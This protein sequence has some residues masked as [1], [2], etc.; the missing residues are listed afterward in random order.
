MEQKGNHLIHD[1]CQN[2]THSVH[3]IRFMN[4]GDKYFLAKTPEKCL[5]EAAIENKMIYLEACLQQYRHFSPFATFSDG[6]L[7][8]EA[9]TTLKRIAIRLATK[10][11]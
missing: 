3:G 1:L 10:W 5:Q 8:V 7:D 2:G 11:I 4:T 9:A 6:L